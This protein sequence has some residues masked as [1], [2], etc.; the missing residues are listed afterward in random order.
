[1]LI[2]SQTSTPV[3]AME[4]VEIY[5]LTQKLDTVYSVLDT[6]IDSLKEATEMLNSLNR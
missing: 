4:A 2:D 5:N 3:S 6:L 1:M